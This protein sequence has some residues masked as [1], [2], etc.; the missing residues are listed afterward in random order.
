MIRKGDNKDT[1]QDFDVNTDRLALDRALFP[2][3]V[4]IQ[5]QSIR[6]KEYLVNSSRIRITS[7]GV[8]LRFNKSDNI[9]L[10]G[11]N[12]DDLYNYHFTLLDD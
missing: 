2:V 10:R 1:I 11:V 4:D 8:I 7:S 9:T 3:E 6:L 5:G 12:L